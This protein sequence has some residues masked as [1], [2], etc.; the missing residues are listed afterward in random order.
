MNPHILLIYALYMDPYIVY[1]FYSVKT[2]IGPYA[3]LKILRIKMWIVLKLILSHD[4]KVLWLKLKLISFSYGV[5]D[6]LRL[7]FPF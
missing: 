2:N 4:L 6:M 3:K 1:T 5:I 7:R